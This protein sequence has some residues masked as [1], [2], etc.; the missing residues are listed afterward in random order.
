MVELKENLKRILKARHLRPAQLARAVGI[1]V[2]TV[3]RW[4]SEGGSVR[5][6]AALK[7]CCDFLGVTV[8]EILF[9]VKPKKNIQD[10]LNDFE[11]ELSIGEYE[12]VLRR[13]KRI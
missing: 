13:K 5:D 4:A 9:G 2:S 3:S 1:P 11:D 7:K 8:D 6:L 12:I 10:I